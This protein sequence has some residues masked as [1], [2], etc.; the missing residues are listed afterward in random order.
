MIRHFSVLALASVATMG[1][2]PLAAQD[3]AGDRVNM[4]IIY[5]DDEC[6][7]S[8]EGEITVCARKAESERYRIPERLRTSSSPLNQSWTE[9]V[10]RYETAGDFGVMSCS[11]TGAGGEAGCTQKMIDAAYRAREEGSDVRFGQL[12]EEARQ[13]RL[14]TIDQ[15]AADEQARVEQLEKAYMERLERERAGPVP[16]EAVD[17]SP[18]PPGIDDPARMPPAE[19]SKDTAFDDGDEEPLPIDSQAPASIGTE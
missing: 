19:P 2:A 3:E 4:V 17:P 7:P 11:P 5:G 15:E 6:P 1:A 10:E 14:S 8:T 13:E 18:P 9:R 16:G 12:I